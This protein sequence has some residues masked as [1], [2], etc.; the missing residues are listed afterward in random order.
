MKTAIASLF[1]AFCVSTASFATPATATEDKAPF[2]TSVIAFP[3]HM[4]LDVV[5][6]NLEGANLTIRIVNEAGITQATQW[7]NKHEKAFR[8]RFD[9]SSLSDGIYKVIVTDGATT[10]T[11]EINISTNVPTPV[12]NRTI[13]I[14]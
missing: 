1:I 7:L 2:E 13:S 6:Q 10:K 12:T 5:V 4:K 9:I 8:T 11:Q 14:D 3:A